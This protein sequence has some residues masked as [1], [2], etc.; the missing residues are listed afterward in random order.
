MATT[1]PVVTPIRLRRPSNIGRWA[2]IL[3]ALTA[4]AMVMGMI[5]DSGR[6]GV[7]TAAPTL[8]RSQLA[9]ADRLEGQWQLWQAGQAAV[10]Q[11]SPEALS[12]GRIEALRAQGAA[13]ARS[14]GVGSAAEFASIIAGLSSNRAE[15][16]SGI[17]DA[18]AHGGY[19]D[20]LSGTWM[21]GE[22][23]QPAV[24]AEHGDFTAFAGAVA[25]PVERFGGLD[26]NLDPD[27]VV[28]NLS[29]EEYGYLDGGHVVIADERDRYPAGGH[30]AN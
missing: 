7:S 29:F 28:R 26:A 17:E 14:Q 6:E 5:M 27:V 9:E 15:V 19:Y 25:E 21:F 4:V 3:A 10:E 30:Q 13:V 1:T 12:V 2:L 22:R 11:A 24:I 8:T 23:P 16:L 20:V 18:R